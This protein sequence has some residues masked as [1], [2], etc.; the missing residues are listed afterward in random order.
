[1]SAKKQKS[2]DHTNSNAI[3]NSDTN[4]ECNNTSSDES[5]SGDNISANL[6]MITDHSNETSDTDHSNKNNNP[7]CFNKKP[8]TKTKLQKTLVGFGNSG[9][10]YN[11]QTHLNTHGIT[12]PAKVFDAILQPTISEMFHCATEQNVC[13]KESINYALVEWIVT[14]L[15]PFYIL[16]NESFIKLIHTLNPYY[17]LPS[18]KYVKVPCTAYTLQI[19]IGKRLKPA[20]VLIKY[21]KRLINFLTTPKQNKQLRKAQKLVKISK[22]N[23]NNNEQEN[24]MPLST[25]LSNKELDL[26]NMLT[27]FDKEEEE[28]I[29]DIDEELEII[30]I[31]NGGKFKLNQPQN[32]DNLEEKVK[33]S[34]YKALDYYWNTPLDCSLIAILLDSCCK[35]M[36]KLDSW[37]CDKAIDLFIENENI[38]SLVNIE[39]NE[40]QMSLFSIMFGSDIILISNKNE[41]DEY[42][43]VD[44]MPTTTNPLN[45]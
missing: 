38:T 16:K 20:E 4:L 39:Q 14:D 42:L 24:C 5:L 19:A 12:K 45:W 32:T 36:K 26:T 10:N 18:N 11:F 21:A 9:F 6:D 30:I 13:Q 2:K 35:S 25:S 44:Q 8:S 43:K 37:K 34:L 17:K 29:I 23:I 15:Q 27:I 28:D 22:E 3:S 40:N 7:N 41:V 1:M 33:K 31:A